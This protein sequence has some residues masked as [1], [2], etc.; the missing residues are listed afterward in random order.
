MIMTGGAALA[1]WDFDRNDEG[2]DILVY[3]ATR[4]PG[5]GE[6][7]RITLVLVALLGALAIVGLVVW[8]VVREP[9]PSPRPDA[10]PGPT[11]P[12]APQV[13]GA[14]S[15]PPRSREG[16]VQVSSSAPGSLVFV[17]GRRIGSAPQTVGLE[18]GAHHIRV[19]KEGFQPFEREV[20]IVPGRTLALEARLERVSPSLSVRADVLGA[21][22]FL[23]RKFL[24]Q[25]PVTVT[26]VEPGRHRI[27][28]SADGYEMYAEDVEIGAGM[29]ELAVSF[30]EVRL[31]ESLA[32]K[33]KHGLG[34]CGGRLGATPEGLRYETDNEKDA[35]SV[36]F[37]DLG[38]LEV[39]YLDKNLRVKTRGGRTYNFTA[40]SADDLL[41]FQKAVEAARE[42]LQ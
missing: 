25:A 28:V 18:A 26:D 21:Q 37:S 5:A 34:S 19:E 15:R 13:S 29:N 36:S 6:R 7:G 1:D 17:D 40:E 3:P 9:T 11:P 23:D 12:T 35:F 10:P 22:V 4:P 8:L 2:G 30:K 24:G 41:V 39:D 32:V 14:P 27:N 31:D 16:E 20:Q 38:P 33:H 42:R